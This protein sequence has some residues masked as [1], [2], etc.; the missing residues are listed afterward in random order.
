MS[1]FKKNSKLV[2]NCYKKLNK[3]QNGKS[4]NLI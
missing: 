1:N 4:N 3:E 2:S